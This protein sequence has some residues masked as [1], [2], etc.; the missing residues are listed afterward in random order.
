MITETAML[1]YAPPQEPHDISQ[2][3]QVLSNDSNLVKHVVV[4]DTEMSD[5]RMITVKSNPGLKQTCAAKPAFIPH[6][7]RNLNFFKA[8]FQKIN[9]HLKSVNWDNLHSVCPAS[10]FP[11]L[12]RLTVLQIC[13]LYSPAKCY[14][15]KKL[16][17]FKRERRALDRKKHKLNR[18]LEDP[19]LLE[20]VKSQT[21]KKLVDIHDEIKNLIYKESSQSEKDAINK[22]RDDPRYFF[23]WSSRKRKCRTGVGPLLD[24]SG[25][26]QHDDKTTSDILQ[27]QFCSVFS[28]PQNPS[29]KFNN[30]PANYNEPLDDITITTEDI[31]KAIKEIKIHSAG[32]DDDMPAILIKKCSATLNYPLYLIWQESLNTG[33]ISPQYKKQIIAPSSRRAQKPQQQIIVLYVLPHTLLKHVNVLLEIK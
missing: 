9:T 22:I 25:V 15:S 26:L 27:N 18:R 17:K 12:V 4:S 20:A 19:K 29:K 21:K 11:E 2:V 24:S 32:S 3:S 30:T 16:S 10:D 23:S 8:D 28:N 7:Y 13:E 31:D 14:R 6:T 1:P 5:H 33:F